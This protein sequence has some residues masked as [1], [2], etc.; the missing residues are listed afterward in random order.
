LIRPCREDERQA[1]FAVVNRAA[2]AYR[3]VIPADRWQEPYMSMEEL[4]AEL[5]AGVRFWGYEDHDELVGI[6]GI[7]DVGEVDLI[8]HAY[9]VPARQRAGVGGELLRH[10][11]AKT[12]RRVLVGTWADAEW[13][14][15]FYE[16]HG[17]VMTTREQT[18]ELLRR[19]WTIPERQIETS[20][21]L[22][23]PP[24]TLG[25]DF[26]HALAV[27]DAGRLAALLHPD[28]DFAGL[29][30]SRSWEASGAQAV[31]DVL[32]QSWFEPKDEIRSLEHVESDSMADR[33]RVGYRFSVTNPDGDFLVEQQAYLA[34]V[35]GRIGFMRVVCSGFRPEAG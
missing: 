5:A 9:V 1:I 26:A 27:K 21:V 20:V 6:M 14:I 10:L 17:F 19:Y 24:L 32:L 13:A 31:L 22:A 29:T 2:E 15:R 28:V 8:R 12:T 7:Q 25:T 35:D 33:E 30:P 4:Q 34:P 18:A 11:R 23:S 3:G 16:R